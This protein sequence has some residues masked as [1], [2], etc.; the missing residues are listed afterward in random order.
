MPWLDLSTGINPV[1]YPTP[2]VAHEA[3]ARLPEKASLSTLEASAASAYGVSDGE[4]VVAAPGTQSLIQIF[5][6]IVPNGRVAV[7]SPTYGEHAH[8]WRA[9]GHV[10]EETPDIE[11]LFAADIAVL[12]NPNNPDG[13]VVPADR[14]QDL[15]VRQQESGG[16]LII[17]EAFA[18]AHEEC[19]LA[20]SIT[21][22]SQNLVVLRSF[23]KF[24]GLAG[25]RLG[26][27]IAGTQLA[28]QIRAALGPWAVSGPT[29]EVGTRALA[30]EAWRIGTRRRLATDQ[31]RLSTLLRKTGFEVVGATALFVL[32]RS[33]SAQER[34]RALGEAGILVRRFT[35]HPDWLRF[36]LPAG[37][38]SW[39]RLQD[40]LGG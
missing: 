35:H 12:T 29:I 32:V 10:V 26:F 7:F 11:A 31:E 34:Y 18:D 30:D 19:S 36:G 8:T 22:R 28:L 17:D 14:L 39:A 24:Y 4:L 37:D 21:A 3:W 15:A 2:A 40:V 6:H 20:P 38:D 9:A 16:L 27:A 23:G 13:R 33:G 1:P 25:A 5:P